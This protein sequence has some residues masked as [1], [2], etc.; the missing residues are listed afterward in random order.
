MKPKLDKIPVYFVPG[1]AASTNIFEYIFLPKERFT[2]H[3]LPWLDPVSSNEPIEDYAFRMA[4]KIKHKNPV[5]VGV[6]FGGIMVQEIS[7]H[8]T[9][10]KVIIISSVKHQSEFPKRLKLAQKTKAYKLFP[11]K[12]L[13][14]I[15]VLTKYAFGNTLKKRMKLYSKYLSMRDPSY[16]DWAVYN[17]LHWKQTEPLNNIVH[18]HGNNDKIFPI[19]N[20]SACTI[21]EGGTHIMILNKSKKI[22]ALIQGIL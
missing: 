19:K 5:L 4:Q 7:K 16:L 18:I 1:L 3:Y 10:K 11:S 14:K 12:S 6:S 13:K 20:I 17:V 2:M 21:V 22:T 9:S 15:E 8:I